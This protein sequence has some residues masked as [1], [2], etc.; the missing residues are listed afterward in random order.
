MAAPAEIV[1]L[2]TDP[3]Y[4]DYDFPTDCATNPPGHA[5]APHAGA[6]GSGAPIEDVVGAEG[7][8]GAFGYFDSGIFLRARKFDVALAEVMFV[9]S[10]GWRKEI[11][12]DD[13]VQNFEYTE[14]AQIFEYY[15]QYY[16]KTDK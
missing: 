1:P 7:V 4:D 16:H 11:N 8:H 5:G 10:E 3:K 13:L 14:K 9:N 2:K 15:P 6:G 12:L